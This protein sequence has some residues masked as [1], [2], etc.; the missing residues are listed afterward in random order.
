MEGRTPPEG[1]V[2][3]SMEGIKMACILAVVLT[4]ARFIFER[5]VSS[6]LFLF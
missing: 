6:T 4:I 5:F 3:P 1:Y 2:Y